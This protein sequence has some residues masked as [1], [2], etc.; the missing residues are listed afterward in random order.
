MRIVLKF[1][2]LNIEPPND[3][4]GIP[5]L[6]NLKSWFFS[7]K[8]K[9]NKNDISNLWKL[10]KEAMN[11][12]IKHETLNAIFKQKG[13][14]YNITIALFWIKSDNYINLDEVNR[15]YFKSKNISDFD[16]INSENYFNILNE[17][18]NKFLGI[19]FSQISYNAW[20]ASNND[21]NLNYL[22]NDILSLV[23]KGH[24]DISYDMI[25]K[26]ITN[27]NNNENENE[28]KEYL[29]GL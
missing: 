2:D 28:I 29:R 3:F 19:P 23:E 16:V 20:A 10:F 11:E 27:T 8:N 21:I 15:S 26:K 14:K 6:N 24:K 7:Y 22:K 12:N 13:I 4:N 17:V 1:F 9:R 18:K 25:I 5:I